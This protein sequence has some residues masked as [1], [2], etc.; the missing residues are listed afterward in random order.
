MTCIGNSQCRRLN[1]RIAEEVCA[2]HAAVPRPVVLGVCGGVN[3]YKS[4]TGMNEVLERRLLRQIEDVTCRVQKNNDSISG[5]V[6]I[7]ES[8]RIRRVVDI[9]TI[10]PA[11]R[12][13]GLNARRNG[14][15]MK[16]R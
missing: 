12:S 5:Q 9:K 6:C 8:G 2:K 14:V 1:V 16:P 4:S 11:Q 15:V 13:Y 10:L 3:A 7:R